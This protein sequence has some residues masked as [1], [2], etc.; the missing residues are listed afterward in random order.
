ME[1]QRLLGRRVLVRGRDGFFTVTAV[2]GDSVVCEAQYSGETV[3]RG[4]SQVTLRD[5][6]S[7]AAGAAMNA[8]SAAELPG[9]AFLILIYM[10]SAI[11]GVVVGVASAVMM[12]TGVLGMVLGYWL[13][14][15]MGFL[16]GVGFAGAVG[17]FS[18]S[19]RDGARKRKRTLTASAPS[20]SEGWRRLSEQR[21]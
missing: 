19:G 16:L 21:V 18:D 6:V 15:T 1:S 20:W 17:A 13:G 8:L 2:A 12:D 4:I 3:V 7:A 11:V 9:R 5:P 14:G 10:C